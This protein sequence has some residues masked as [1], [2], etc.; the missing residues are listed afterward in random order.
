M[1]GTLLHCL[2][3]TLA[4]LAL[5]AAPACAE[6]PWHQPEPSQIRDGDADRPAPPRSVR[7]AAPRRE[8]SAEIQESLRHARAL[9]QAFQHAAQAIDP[10]VVH[11]IQQRQVRVM[12]G[13]FDM[14]ERRLAPTG[15][16]SGVVIT[17][18]GYIVT[19]HHV[20]AGAQRVQVRLNDGR[21]Y[22]G[23]I[24]GTDPA[25]D[26]GVVKIEAENL[27]SARFG[28]SD[29]LEVGEW[30]LAVG[31]PFGV[32]NNTVT[33]GIVSA[34]GRRGLA[35]PADR[36][37]DFIQTDAAINPGNSG[38]PLVNLEGEVIGINSQI[39]TRTGGSVGIGFAIPSSIAAFVV[40]SLINTGRVERG[41][42][43]VNGPAEGQA[44]T[45]E[46][47]S[48]FE[49]AGADPGTGALVTGV[50]PGGPADRAGLEPGD[51]VLSFN[52][53]QTPDFARFRNTVAFTAPGTRASMEI[54][55]DGQRTTLE[56]V[57]SDTTRGR[58]L[59]PGGSAF[60]RYGF[61][62][63]TLPPQ[64][65]RQ[66][67]IESGVVVNDVEALGPAAQSDLRPADII[68]HIDGIRTADDESFDRAIRAV[69]AD[70]PIRVG[71]LRPS[72]RQQGYIDI[73]PRD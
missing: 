3:V 48:M 69:P 29:A 14:G 16:G 15:T 42:L 5:V 63:V 72:T 20:I 28:D 60:P 49:R 37:E 6:D 36:F 43:G 65:A 68:V 67:G 26:L 25:T 58:A 59:L 10:S 39:A 2:G 27:I 11:I 9:S 8:L 50:I 54:M 17:P 71:V 55:R 4:G 32:F 22:D 34:K 47:R 12:R 46:H 7:D 70:E 35:G 56:A 64:A 18:D 53:R 44:V 21:E 33:A 38:G 45:R 13:F 41:W 23:T 19:N 31:S 62:V 24:I 73:M 52:G 30:V 61:T 66:L 1:T 40:D 51:V 57:V